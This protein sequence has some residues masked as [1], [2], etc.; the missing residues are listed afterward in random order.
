MK[1]VHSWIRR[2]F[3]FSRG[4]TRAFLLLLLILAG[5]VVS[6]WLLQRLPPP[7]DPTADRIVLDSLV[8]LMEAERPAAPAGRETV[9]LYRFNPNTLSVEE[10]QRLGVPQG[11]ARRIINY[12]SKAGDYRYRS[13]LKKIYGL[14]DSLYQRLYPYMDLPA[15]KPAR[16]ERPPREQGQT[17]ARREPEERRLFPRRRFEITPFDI[18]T[19]D[20]LQLKQIR[21]IG[22]KLSARIVA[23]RN[24]LGG[25][26]RIEQ[27]GEVYGL[28][29]EMVDSLRKYSFVAAGYLPNQVA[30]NSATADELRG[31]PYISPPVARAIVAFREQ[32]GPYQ[33]VEDILKIKLVDENLFRRLQPYLSL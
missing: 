19:A 23:F 4:E 24:R 25:Y 3:N 10:W 32:H 21:G 12:R 14:T 6:P 31:H 17:Y 2:Y 20:T 29:A 5:I 18:N 9:E 22:S 26:H 11:V 16:E 13:D 33:Q 1:K 8:A 30:L 15:E 27:L 7:Y 28:P